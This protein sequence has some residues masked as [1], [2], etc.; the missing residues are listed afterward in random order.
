[1]K[2]IVLVFAL[3]ISTLALAQETSSNQP[4]KIQIGIHYVGNLKNENLISDEFNGLIGVDARYSIVNEE[5]LNFY[6]GLTLDYL[7]NK[8]QFFKKDAIVVNPNIGIE[9]DVFKSNFRPFVNVGFA[10]FSSEFEYFALNF[11]PAAP[12]EIASEKV[13]FSGI[14]INP[15]FRIHASDLIFIE[16]SYKYYPVNSKDFEGKANVHFINLGFGIKL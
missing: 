13:N 4:K 7:K 15:G 8:D 5:S 11:D 10:F 1:M 6:G 16:A 9:Y 12:L 2:K 14:T 3:T